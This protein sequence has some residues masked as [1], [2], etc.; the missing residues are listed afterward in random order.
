M[1]GIL[2]GGAFWGWQWWQKRLAALQQNE[3]EVPTAA[4]ERRTIELTVEVAGDLEPVEVLEVK[5]EVSAR[6]KKLHVEL[7]QAVQKGAVLA[8]LDNTELLTE[9]AQIQIEIQGAELELKKAEEDLQRDELL[10]SRQLIPEKDVAERRSARDL[11]IN[12][13]DRARK[14]MQTLQDRLAKTTIMAPMSGVI[15]EMPVVEGQVVVA[16]ASVNSGTL[17][18][19]LANLQQLLI[20]THVNQI[21]VAR[22]REGMPLSFTVDSLPGTRM[23]GRVFRIAPTATIRNN[24]KGYQVEIRI[25]EPDPRLRPGMTADV[26]IPIAQAEDV[27]AVP[28]AAV[29]NQPDGRRVVYVQGDELSGQAEE[30]AVEVG[31]TNIHYAE[32]KSG[33][34]ERDVVLLARPLRP[35]GS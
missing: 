20:K 2:G 10:F 26:V 29:F 22:L 1:L 12:R 6:I 27:L 21:D 16:A 13:L 18:M 5:S 30:R 8:E 31:L 11:A 15:L 24:I 19:K 25:D 9:Q 34:K 33:L 28:L 17:L 7:G 23:S 14:R 35:K 4:V 3:R 32:I